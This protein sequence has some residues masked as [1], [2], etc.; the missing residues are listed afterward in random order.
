MACTGGSVINCSFTVGEEEDGVLIEL[1]RKKIL[2]ASEYRHNS[3]ISH[4]EKAQNISETM[5]RLTY[6]LQDS[7][8]LFLTGIRR[9]VPGITNLS[10]ESSM[11]L[12][13]FNW[14]T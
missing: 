13:C 10:P 6:I 7:M 8:G 5:N 1:E 11:R 12:I 2:M 4:S 3:F 14:H 9:T